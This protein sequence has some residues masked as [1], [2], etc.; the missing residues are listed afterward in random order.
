[1]ISKQ[2][3]S[4]KIVASFLVFCL[5]VSNFAGLGI[6]LVSNAADIEG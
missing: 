6:M 2:K 1:M 4:Q 5:L 3:I